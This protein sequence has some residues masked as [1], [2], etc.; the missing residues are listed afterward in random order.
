MSDH[1]G[2]IANDTGA[3]VRADLNLLFQAI[4]NGFSGTS[5]PAAPVAYQLWNDTANGLLKQRNAANTDWLVRGNIAE[6]FVLARSSNTILGVADRG[7]ML[8]CTS[9]FTQ[10]FAAAATLGDGW[11][12]FIR[13]NGSGVVTLDP[14]GA[15]TIDGETTLALQPGESCIVWCTGSAFVTVGLASSVSSGT[16]STTFTFNGSGG[17]S[18]TIDIPWIK[19]GSR[20]TLFIPSV[21]ATAGTGSTQLVG[22]TALDA[23]LRPA[24]SQHKACQIYSNNAGV[25]AAGMVVVTAAGVITVFKGLLISD[26]WT[27]GHT[28]AGLGI[29]LEI[30]YQ[31]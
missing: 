28:N 7:R 16:H 3:A 15:E 1:D 22:N 9:T 23:E 4:L 12:C 6:T 10:T 21:L 13:N 30:S 27:T 24:A 20:V 11:F 25:A 19:V 29:G 18:G 5:A 17:T 31:T 2:V 14:D 8:N 26:T